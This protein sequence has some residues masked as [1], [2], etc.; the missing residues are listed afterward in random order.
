MTCDLEPA[1]PGRLFRV[2]KGPDP[3]AFLDWAQA[4]EDGT[5]GNRW[6]DP[7]SSYRVLYACSQRVGA[8]I[9]T[10]LVAEQGFRCCLRRR[11]AV[12]R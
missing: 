9:E 11:G 6:D 7:K 8:L 2:G 5:F 12:P 3:W 4:G 1:T 10:L